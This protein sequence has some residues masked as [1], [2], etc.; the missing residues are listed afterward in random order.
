MNGLFG[1]GQSLLLAL[2]ARTG[3]RTRGQK[4]R[5]RALSARHRAG[6]PAPR[7]NLFGLDFPNPIGMAAGFDKNARVPRA[8]LAMG[9]GFVEVGTLTP[10]AQSGN[11][12]PRMFRSMT[13]RAV[14]N[15]LGFNNEG[16]EAALRRL[17]G[18]AGRHGRRQY[19]RGTRQQGP[20]RRLRVGHQAPGGGGELL[21]HQYFLAQHAGPARSPGA[22]GAR[23][24][25]K[26]RAAGARRHDGASRRCWSSS[27][28]I[29]PMTIC[30]KWCA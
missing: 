5:A 14:I 11:P 24:L 10:R 25:L 4:S 20:H 27:P 2:A 6:R 19:R 9:F 17:Q 18:G 22:G 1:L 21:H 8:L 7:P 30:P 16:Q 28:P 29:S 3:A 13:D 12:S 15:R 26:A 23:A